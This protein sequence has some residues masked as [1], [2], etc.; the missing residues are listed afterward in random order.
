MQTILL[1]VGAATIL[2]CGCYCDRQ[3]GASG[4]S[5]QG[6]ETPDLSA[7][8][9]SGPLEYPYVAPP[10]RFLRILNR[11]REIQP[12]MGAD[13]VVAL[14][15]SPDEIAPLYEP[16]KMNPKQIGHSYV[17][18]LSRPR[19]NAW[20]FDEKSVLV[21]FDLTNKVTAVSPNNLD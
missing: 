9:S 10:A 20:P 18:I 14:L 19:P 11:Y 15:G 12:G 16:K 3:A 21:R 17:Y 13:D 1:V 4:V 5:A 6:A 7:T 8:Q 2:L